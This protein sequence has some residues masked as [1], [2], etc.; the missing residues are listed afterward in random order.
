MMGRGYLRAPA[1]QA[2]LEARTRDMRGEL[3]RFASWRRRWRDG[4]GL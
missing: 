2:W 4:A 3:A 1:A